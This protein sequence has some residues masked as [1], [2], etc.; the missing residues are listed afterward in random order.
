V[1]EFI[2]AFRFVVPIALVYLLCGLAGNGLFGLFDNGNGASAA[3]LRIFR[4]GYIG[5]AFI[6]AWFLWRSRRF[7]AK[8]SLWICILLA[9]IIGGATADN[10]QAILESLVQAPKVSGLPL[11]VYLLFFL[12]FSTLVRMSYD[13]PSRSL[14]DIRTAEPEG[15]P[16]LILFLSEISHLGDF[17][18]GSPSWLSGG[19]RIIDQDLDSL[20]EEKSRNRRPWAWEQLLRAINHHLIKQRLKSVTVVASE[21]SVKQ[22]HLFAGVIAEYPALAPI[23]FRIFLKDGEHEPRLA[24][25]DRH[26]YESGGWSFEDFTELSEAMHRLLKRLQREGVQESDLMIDFTGGKKVASVVAAA[27]TFNR[28]VNAQ[29]VETESPWN[30]HGYQVVTA[31]EFGLGA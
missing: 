28:S 26:A 11:I 18:D 10:L 5:L 9:A 21:K 29:Y 2:G 17:P 27:M 1:K 13:E 4:I 30:V 6:G 22:A 16:D 25:L 14:I 3:C 8:I 15:R 20:A 24:K 12:C 7:N 31:S 23:D 19:N